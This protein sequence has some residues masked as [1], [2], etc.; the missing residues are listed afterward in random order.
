MGWH[1]ATMFAL[2]FLK[3]FPR[4][5]VL[6]VTFHTSKCFF[7]IGKVY[8]LDFNWPAFPANGCTSRRVNAR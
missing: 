6:L 2:V 3:L 1:E 7:I 8:D 5:F 4:G